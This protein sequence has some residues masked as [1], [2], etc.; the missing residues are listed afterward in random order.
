LKLIFIIKEVNGLIQ[1]YVK[2]IFLLLFIPIGFSACNASSSTSSELQQVV[3]STTIIGDIVRAIA[4]DTVD[5]TVLLPPGADPHTYEPTPQDMTRLADAKL[6]FLN[7]GGL[8]ELMEPLIASAGGSARVIHLSEKIT[9]LEGSED[10]AHEVTPDAEDSH[11][12]EGGDP[13][14]WTDPN[15]ILVWIDAIEAALSDLNPGEAGQYQAKADQYRAELKALDAWIAA[16][17]SQIPPENRLLVTDHLEFTY[18]ARRYGFSLVGAVIPNYST[19]ADTSAQELA[20]LEDAIRAQGVRA[21]FVGNTVNPALAQRVANDTGV[22]LVTLLTG[23]LTEP[24]GEADT[25]LDYMHHNV[26]KIV[27]ALK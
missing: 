19:S 21:I 17:V 26:N 20:A 3:A 7:G 24:G 1:R 13:H 6:I 18:F 22:H 14:V 23:S 9:L 15:N 16:E 12:H 25:Y 10:L 8:E 5:L 4:G 2:L 27:Q 11:L